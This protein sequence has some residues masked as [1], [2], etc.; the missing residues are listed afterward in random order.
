MKIPLSEFE[1]VIGGTMLKRGLAYF[2]KGAVTDFTKLSAKEYEAMVSGT[3]DYT[4]QLKV[5]NDVVAQHNCDCPYDLGPVCKHVVAA[6]F[7]LQQEELQLDLTKPKKPKK[8]KAKTKSVSRQVNELL[9]SISHEELKDFVQ[10]NAK[11]DRKFRNYFLA[12]FAQRSKNQSKEFY[13][14]QIHNILQAGK[15]RD[16][17][18]GWSEMNYVVKTT[19]PILE[20]AKKAFGQND[21]KTVFFI[22]TAL[23]EEMTEALQY[24]DDSNGDLGYFIEEALEMLSK[25][26][27]EKLSKSLKKELFEYCISAFNKKLFAGWDWH[28]EMLNLAA[29]L[30]GKESEANIILK[31]LD[32]VDGEYERERAQLFK[33][34]LIKRF[35]SEK[36][37]KKYI[38]QHISNSS[39]R[40]KEIEKAFE[41]KNFK[42]V[43]A[44]S[45]DGIKCDEKD[46]PGLV[47]TWVNWLLKVAQA[48][49]ETEKI[50][51]YAR[52]LFIDN[53]YPEQDYYQILKETI[54]PE[55][56]KPFL[57]DLIEEI[58]PKRNWKYTELI[59]KIYI[60]EKWWDRLF[61]ML[62]Q[63]TSLRNIE[64]NEK[65]LK[66]DY[67]SELIELYSERLKNYVE[68]Y[69][70]R[71]HYQ[72]ACRYLRRMKKLGGS[73]KV[74]AL[75]DFFREKYPQ[76]RALQDE[77]SRV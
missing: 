56:W 5:K 1:Q 11:K 52:F 30:V 25:L 65:Y 75:I 55:N 13:R 28:L 23:L 21:F 19:E 57:E 35:K 50:I 4:V 36:E 72:T 54:E 76:R 59:R 60:N 45:K 51:E 58:T 12:S 69:V 44:L 61:I 10:E 33:L 39:I 29:E 9:N 15:G 40:K 17:W 63:N 53:F 16:G 14:K 68:K 42:R 18:I 6:I 20:N 34:D 2:K 46:K 66:E 47:K 41:N 8:K 24:G 31:C 43:T 67:A 3:E 77:L 49:N 7:Y 22:A 27:Q 48:Q 73:E 74:E 62:N 26:G 38:D 70:G 32:S 71:T 64:D 37:A